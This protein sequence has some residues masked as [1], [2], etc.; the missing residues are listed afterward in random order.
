VAG[1][2][3]EATVGGVA[4]GSVTNVEA[5]SITG[6]TG[7]DR[8]GGA[9][10][11]WATT[12][13]SGGSGDDVAVVDASAHT[14]SF[15]GGVNVGG[16]INNATGVFLT[17]SGIE[18]LEFTGNAAGGPGG[19]GITGGAGDDVLTGLGGDDSFDGAAGNDTINGGA[20]TDTL[21]GGS[22]VD[23]LSYAD[24]PTRVIV[25]MLGT[26]P[27]TVSGII[28]QAGTAVEDFPFPL[29]DTTDTISGFE[30]VVGSAFND[31]LI[32][33]SNVANRLEGG[34]G[35]DTL[36][37]SGTSD[38][39]N[40]P[41]P[42]AANDTLLG[43]VG[44]DELR[45]TR[46]ADHLDGGAGSD[47]LAFLDPSGSSTTGVVYGGIGAV[48]VNVNLATG[49]SDYDTSDPLNPLGILVSIE[50]V[51]GSAGNDIFVGG[52]EAHA[53]D[54]LGNGV[55]ESFR[56]LGGDDAITG[57]IGN[58]VRTRVDYS[59]NT[60]TQSVNVNLGTGSA[61]DGRGGNDTLVR[62]DQV[63]G[64]AGDDTLFGG[65]QERSA[66]GAFFEFF[67]GNAGNDTI[68]GAG[69]DTVVGAAGSDRM[70]YGNSPAP[71]IVNLGVN[72]FVVGADTVPGGTA[73]D[74]FGFTDT[75][76][77]VDQ[78]EGSNFN[79]TLVGG[80]SNHRLIGGAGDDTLV[81][82]TGGVEASYQTSTAGVTANLATG[83]AN[84]AF[85]GTDTLV[86]IDDLRGS[87]FNDTLIGSAATNRIAGHGGDDSI[88]GGDS[89]DFASYSGV[90][91]A[92]GG[93]NAFIENG[94]G[95]VDDGVGST[96]TLTNIEGLIGT[97][98]A[99]TLTGGQGDQWFIGRGGSDA[100][101][102]GDGSDW[103]SYISSPAGVTVNLDV[104]NAADGWGG[105][106]ALGGIDTLTSIENAE[107]SEF[108]DTL[109]GDGGENVLAGGGGN[110]TLTG[111]LADDIFDYNALSDAGTTGDIITDFQPGGGDVL[112]LHDLLVSIGAGADP[113]AS[114]SGHLRFFD[115]GND[116][117]VQVDSDGGDDSYMTLATLEGVSDPSLITASDYI[118]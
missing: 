84:D 105:V 72:P 16:I 60:S 27:I 87:D 2:V 35:N 77:N 6:G 71:V 103:V 96:D 94:A 82:V 61:S 76:L 63:F 48:G 12:T 45:Q 51:T 110:D 54:L 24:S 104:G 9:Y 117:L 26:N 64:G 49:T 115:A 47:R 34:A 69:T 83:T 13:L 65:S 4:A 1:T 43:G 116:T 102:G 19:P 58:G 99:D 25:N 36:Q 79:D 52:D 80:A 42:G 92:N 114:G 23:T 107:G 7:N 89:I 86:N 59:T 29:L 112:D 10:P 97:H 8:I 50:N 85:G 100:I 37:G 91:L 66:N 111:G 53:P 88:D 38:G 28:V 20:G 33:T 98:S 3:Y 18:A 113:F 17:L 55:T 40:P 22:G 73:R 31:F 14:A 11:T 101:D 70:N 118:L 62:I 32:G 108:D 90:P 67:R 15:S 41:V 81:G 93:I 57:A 46:G 5:I 68:N 21:V 109:I 78:V 39:I 56:P 30:N 74:G 44:D 95:S 106:W 75:L